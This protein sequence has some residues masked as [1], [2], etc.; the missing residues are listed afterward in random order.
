ML[1]SLA[2][3]SGSP[4]VST[5]ALG[6]TLLWPRDVVLVE[7][8][9]VGYSATLAGF[10][11]G[12]QAAPSTILDLSPG[13]DF[14]EHLLS[15]S[16]ALTDDQSMMRRLIPGITSPL[17]GHA[18]SARWEALALALYDL[19]R[20][21]VDIICDLGRVHAPSFA[22]PIMQ[23]SDV[24]ILLLRPTIPATFAALSTIKA[25][26]L[27]QD[28]GLDTPAFHLATIA[29]PDTYSDSETSRALAQPSIA[30]LPWAPKHAAALTYGRPRP[31]G[32]D[33]SSYTRALR[34]SAAAI[35]T[36]AQRRRAAIQTFRGETR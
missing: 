24:S 7:A 28:D 32:F 31:R 18:L 20:A 33:S 35:T 5:T 25:R 12:A 23:A 36:V 3:A 9:T 22:A 30:H 29:A 10:F 26:H 16:V 19:E 8:D 15:R 4:G 11:G 14:E 34:S 1:I 17:H 6:L 13:A 21:G 2:S 27:A